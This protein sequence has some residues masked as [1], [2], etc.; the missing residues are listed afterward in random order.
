MQ[1]Q[2]LDE[3][4][5][6][7]LKGQAIDFA[8][9]TA[10]EIREAV[11]RHKTYA[12]L[13]Q[14][15][16][17]GIATGVDKEARQMLEANAKG[18]ALL[19]LAFTRETQ[20]LLSLL[21]QHEIHVLLIKGFPVAHLYYPAS[22]LRHRVDV[23]IYLEESDWSRVMPILKKAGYQLN[24]ERTNSLSSKQFTATVPSKAPQSI[25]FDIHKRISNRQVFVDLLRFDACWEQ[26]IALPG[27]HE[28]AQ[29]LSASHQLILCCLHRLAHGRSTA[30]NR[31][32]WLYDVHLM[33]QSMSPAEQENFVKDALEMQVGAVCADALIHS[34]FW[35]E[36]GTDPDTQTR[37][38]SQAA[39]EPSAQLL[40]AG[41]LG[42][43]MSDFNGQAG[44]GN[45]LSFVK[46]TLI[47]QLRS[48]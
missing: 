31:M 9:F 5:A 12:M 1:A 15:L 46:E 22:Y 10:D 25:V 37:L 13:N 41:K 19:D 36:T 16:K 27:V 2:P 24:W 47:N 7:A 14:A 29:T 6:R 48:H 20:R 11:S 8:A 33:S 38:L 4:M 17:S 40:H 30:R 23:D 42:W 34:A 44:L 3:L 39:K 26:R 35:F 43:L 45:K 28:R 21:G 32:T 18:F